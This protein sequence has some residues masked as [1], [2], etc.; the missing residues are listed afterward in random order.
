MKQFFKFLFASCLG[1][2]LALGLLFFVLIMVGS[3]FSSKDSKISSNSVLLLEFNDVIPEKT[4]NVAQNNFSFQSEKSIGVHRIKDLIKKAQ[5]DKN[6]HGIV[7]KAPQA[8]V[9]GLVTNSILRDAIQ[10]FRDS[11]D[12]FVYAYGDFFSNPSYLL[13][14][15][16]DS[17]YANPNGTVDINGYSAMIPFMKEGLD[18]LGVKMN[19]FY[20]GD[21]KSATEPFRR[22]NMSPQNK[23]QTR[24]Y[25]SDYYNE[26][27]DDVA[28]SRGT[29]KA[30]LEEVINELDFDNIDKCIAN[31]IIDGK[32]YW[33]EF[34]DTIRDKLGL[35]EGKDI[36]YVD[37]A[38]YDSKK[39]ISKGSSSNCLLYTSPSPRD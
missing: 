21:F 35:A 9:A 31:N 32:A 2:F 19:V 14:S 5:T 27:L 20:A 25:L 33:Y 6:I 23:I 34:E 8:S 13:A 29:S 15:A 28:E 26:F 38:E 11:T 30:N 22:N 4:G 3:V 12:K 39:Y 7:Y 18:K 24:E 10:E 16:A 36:N 17:I 1:T 37:L